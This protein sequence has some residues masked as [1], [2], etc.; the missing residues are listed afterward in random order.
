MT[1]STLLAF[2]ESVKSVGMLL[3]FISG[4]VIFCALFVVY[5]LIFIP[6]TLAIVIGVLTCINKMTIDSHREAVAKLKMRQNIMDYAYDVLNNKLNNYMENR[7]RDRK[8]SEEA[9][10][11]DTVIEEL[12]NFINS[13]HANFDKDIVSS[14]LYTEEFRDMFYNEISVFFMLYT[15]ENIEDIARWTKECAEFM[16]GHHIYREFV[17]RFYTE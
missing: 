12:H 9:I 7:I 8:K 10:T 6:L 14:V 2:V 5:P 11:T 1:N 3:G 17:S 13:I 16:V 4:V 15:T